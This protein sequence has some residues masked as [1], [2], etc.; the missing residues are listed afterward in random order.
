MKN[1]ITI[2][3]VLFSTLAIQAQPYQSIFYEDTTRWTAFECVI[4]GFSYFTSSIYDDTTINNVQ[5]KINHL[6]LICAPN[7][8]EMIGFLRE[9]TLTGKVWYKPNFEEDKD[10]LLI[11]DLSLQKGD[12]FGF[13]T[14]TYY[15]QKAD[16][17]VDSVYYEDS[18]KIIE[19]TVY[20]WCLADQK[21]RFIE[22][23]GPS[24]GIS[25]YNE[26][27]EQNALIFKYHNDQLVYTS[28]NY[29]NVGYRDNCN[30]AVDI[31]NEQ[32]LFEIQSAGN[33]EVDLL[34]HEN[35]QQVK[36]TVYNVNGKQVY[37]RTLQPGN[38]QICLNNHGIHIFRLQVGANIT[39]FKLFL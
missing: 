10:E 28:D 14:N 13:T 6:G 35:K 3:F 22:G 11:M 39:S 4:D 17:I 26:R 29:E 8:N 7:F 18:R 19:F 2:A 24:N 12:S 16:W 38:N 37:C 34:V 36:L 33:M 30:V 15:Q 20:S 21:L 1:I 32:T 31:L 27:P 5:Y 25:Y 9:D 23:I